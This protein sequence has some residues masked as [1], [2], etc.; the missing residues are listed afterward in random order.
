MA[1][2]L[3]RS[4]HDLVHEIEQERQAQSF[5][6]CRALSQVHISMHPCHHLTKE[7]EEELARL[8]QENLWM[9]HRL[10]FAQDRSWHAVDLA[11]VLY[12]TEGNKDVLS[13][14]STLEEHFPLR[15]LILCLGIMLHQP[16]KLAAVRRVT[17]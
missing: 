8:R 17:C 11:D 6:S 9:R 13:Q 12:L 14:H 10:G 2:T 16:S 15:F 4:F 7:Y 5:L 3:F 1:T